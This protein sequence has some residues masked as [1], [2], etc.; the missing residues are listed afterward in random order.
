[1]EM[2]KENKKIRTKEHAIE[3][4]PEEIIPSEKTAYFLIECEIETPAGKMIK[5]QMNHPYDTEY[6]EN[7]LEILVAREDGFI[8]KIQI[9][10]KWKSPS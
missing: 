1:M 2:D 9:P 3:E 8:R 5:R 6:S 10:V 4:L 7:N